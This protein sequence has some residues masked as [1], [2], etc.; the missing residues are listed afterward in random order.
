MKIPQDVSESTRRRNPEL[1][2][3]NTGTGSGPQLQE[4]KANMEGPKR[5]ALSGNERRRKG[6]DERGNKKYR[7]SI[8]LFMPDYTRRDV[9]GATSTLIDCLI[10]ARR[11]LEVYSGAQGQGG[12]V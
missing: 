12:K 1:Y 7:V 4:R 10:A 3:Q 2:G 9:D 11:R 5:K 6:L 8:T